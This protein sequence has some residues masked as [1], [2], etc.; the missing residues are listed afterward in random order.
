MK[1]CKEEQDEEKRSVQS[2]GDQRL[3]DDQVKPQGNVQMEIILRLCEI[4]HCYIGDLIEVRV[5]YEVINK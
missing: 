1:P 2:S 4:F 3:L 5:I